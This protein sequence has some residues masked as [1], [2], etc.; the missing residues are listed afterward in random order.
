MCACDG[1]KKFKKGK[2]MD[3]IKN[4]LCRCKTELL[5]ASGERY[6]FLYCVQQ[7]LEWALDPMS[8]ATPVDTVLGD[9]V[10]IMD[11]PVSSEDCLA[12]PRLPLS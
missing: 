7:A 2:N 12:V 10:G 5:Q 8:C 11:T 4:E 3:Y 6:S 1:S 9:K